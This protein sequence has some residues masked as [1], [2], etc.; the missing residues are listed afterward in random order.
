MATMNVSIT[1]LYEYDVM[2]SNT[3]QPWDANRPMQQW[4]RP[5]EEGEDPTE[6][7]QFW[8]Y[9]PLTPAGVECVRVGFYLTLG[10]ASKNNLVPAEQSAANPGNA[11]YWTQKPLAIPMRELK[12]GESLKNTPFGMVLTVEV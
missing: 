12:E 11:A 6:V 3:G 10:E 8:T 5:L 2:G 4:A 9:T 1:A 7:M